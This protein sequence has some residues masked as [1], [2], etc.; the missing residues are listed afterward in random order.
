MKIKNILFC[1]TLSLISFVASAQSIKGVVKGA[2]NTEPLIGASIYWAGTSVGVSSALDGSF[3][4]HRV[5]GYVQ[6]IA[7]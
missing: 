1:F 2:D 3:T 5:K 7:S 4:I 6:L